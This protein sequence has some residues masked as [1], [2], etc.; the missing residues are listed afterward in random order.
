MPAALAANLLAAFADD[1]H[2]APRQEILAAVTQKH[3]A[4]R[5]VTECAWD[6]LDESERYAL[7]AAAARHT[8]PACA[9]ALL[10]RMEPAMLR[11]LDTEWRF[12]LLQSAARMPAAAASAIAGLGASGLAILEDAER[13]ALIQS[14]ARVSD[15]SAHAIAG[16][17]AA[18]LAAPESAERTALLESAAQEP[19]AAEL[20]ARTVGE[21]LSEPER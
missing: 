1:L 20:T 13:A 19:T 8:H 4:I 18:G 10:A 3:S 6:A 9:S 21:S 11:S 15:W 16:L 7:A 5:R 2:G 12:A 17:D 14:A